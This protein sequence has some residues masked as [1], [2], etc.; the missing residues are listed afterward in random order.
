MAFIEELRQRKVVRVAV[1]YL[2][3]AWLGVQVASVALPAF[4]APGWV[5]RVLMLVLALGFPLALIL[6]WAID[7]TPDG[8]RYSPGGVGWKRMV[9]ISVGLG[10]LA[11]GWYFVG[12]PAWRD[13]SES[14]AA[15]PATAR[16]AA[17]AT[18]EKKADVRSIAVLP[19][20]NMSRDPANEY[21]S[22]GLAETTLDMLAKINGLKVIARTSSFAFKGKNSDVREIGRALDAAHLLE[23]SVQQSGKMV[24]ITAQLIRASD[25]THLWSEQYDRQLTDVFQIQDEIAGEVVKA[26]QLALPAAEQ[27]RLTDKRTENVAAYQEYLRGNAL[28]PKRRVAEMREALAHFERAIELDPGYARA[29]AAASMTL[30]LLKT[31]SGSATDIEQA[32]RRRYVDEAL[33]LDPALGEAYAARAGL[34]EDERN[35]A[36]AEENY[37]RAIEL[38]PSFATAYQWYAEFLQREMGALDRALPLLQRAIELD[39]LSPI[40]RS[41][42]AVTLAANNRMDEALEANAQLLS[43]NPGFAT[44]YGT[45]ANLLEAKGDLV[46]ALRNMDARVKADPA[47]RGRLTSR[48]GTLLRF[49][50]LAQAEACAGRMAIEVG[51]AEMG[52]LRVNLLN[53]AGKFEDAY[54]LILAEP[55]PKDPWQMLVQQYLTGRHKEALASMK[56][57]MP[58]LFEKPARLLSNFPGDAVLAGS[59]LVGSGA[60]AQGRELLQRALKANANR[61]HT[62]YMFGRFWSDAYA[63][64]ALGDTT[65]AC[66]ALREAVAA[67]NFLEVVAVENWPA[68]AETRKQPCFEQAIAPARAKARAQVEAARNAGLL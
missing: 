22:D 25:G 59:I 34:S 33:R 53:A 60:T 66:A 32:K 17:V 30:G 19:F 12:Q 61:P 15:A 38:A 47:A 65:R 9:A 26:L 1:A 64:G 36:A 16:A 13:K 52:G 48:C 4:E 31:Y 21:F 58:E 56:Q 45:R 62:Q 18:S 23:G 10:A 5:L 41:E 42:Y 6:T 67:G 50:A 2:V 14:V 54:T 49:G 39:P 29:Y 7:L 55:G 46:G 51:E 68:L 8:P 11:L 24:R 40:I 57:L 44:A 3:V 63:W 35:P 27:E 28:L 20:V 43:E 37:K